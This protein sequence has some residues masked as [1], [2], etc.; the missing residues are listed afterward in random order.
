MYDA[1]IE[2]VNVRYGYY[3]NGT[4]T[5]HVTG[6]N[7]HWAIIGAEQSKN[8]TLLYQDARENNQNIEILALT[9]NETRNATIVFNSSTIGP[10]KTDI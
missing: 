7:E 5:T 8:G 1:N 3:I 10:I 9:Y 6:E 4:E 2:F